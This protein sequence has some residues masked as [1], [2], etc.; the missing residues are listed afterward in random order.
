M[1]TGSED[2]SAYIY[3]IGSAQVVNKTK[4]MI[5]GDSVTDIAVNP[6]Y[7]EW[8]TSC[9]DGCVRVFRHPAR[10]LAKGVKSSGPGS[11]GIPDKVCTIK[12]K[13][14]A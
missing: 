4:N 10:K 9:I 13:V 14:T 12:E 1:V 5:H 8:A 6:K 11:G 7:Y 3:D 2:R